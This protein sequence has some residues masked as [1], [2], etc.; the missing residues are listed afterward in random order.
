MRLT[1]PR[2]SALFVQCAL[3]AFLGGSQGGG[4][5]YCPPGYAQCLAMGSAPKFFLGGFCYF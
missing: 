1:I 3:G 5:R 2:T 4:G